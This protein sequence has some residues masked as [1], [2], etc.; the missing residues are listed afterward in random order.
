MMEL[1][2][3]GEI[4]EKE[5]SQIYNETMR[6]F[7][8]TDE[9]VVYLDADLMGS[10]KTGDLWK[11]FPEK[12]FN[13]GIQEANMVGVACGMYLAGF[14]PYIHTFTPF[15]S[16]R[17]FDQLF[18]SVA[19]AHK[20][21]HVIGSDAGIAASFNGGTH[22]CFEDIALMRTIPNSCIVDVSDGVMFRQMLYNT[23][24]YE[25][26][27]Y[28]RTPRRGLSDIYPTD[29]KFEVGKGKILRDGNDATI[30]ASGMQ[31]AEALKAAEI[32][33]KGGLEIRVVDI[34]T[35]KPIDTEL[36]IKCAKETGLI[37]TTENHN[38]EGGLG[39]AVASVICKNCPIPVIKNGVKD[40]FGQVGGE[41][42][43]RKQYYITAEDIAELTD[44]S[45]EI[46]AVK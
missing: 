1:R 18:V 10:L 38:I 8:K 19:Y 45:L 20:S 28:F 40:T 9:N 30:I 3:N 12:V 44:L 37:I 6:D 25:G 35:I 32:L 29:T 42:F 23:R 46:K 2:F 33:K 26:L 34:V 4:P 22:M 21:I 13:I 41:D 36:I 31:V 27:V 7:F 14:K 24:D 15:A 43:L 5:I 17:V 16:R 39:D 11:E